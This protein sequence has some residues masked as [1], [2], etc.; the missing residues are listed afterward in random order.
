MDVEQGLPRGDGRAAEA[1]RRQ[2]EEVLEEEAERDPRDDD[3][4]DDEDLALQAAVSAAA[5]GPAP[6]KG[7]LTTSGVVVMGVDTD[8]SAE[9]KVGDSLLVT[10]SDR[11]R[12][13]TTD[14]WS[15]RQHGPG[16]A[17]SQH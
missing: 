9:I 14:E 2:A 15:R 5:A 3:G 16:P 11:F 7:R 17:I 10:V 6:G 13:M 8:F 4:D 1:E 12:N